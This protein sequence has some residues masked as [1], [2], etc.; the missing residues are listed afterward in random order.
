MIVVRKNPIVFYILPRP[1]PLF[2]ASHYAGLLSAETVG[3]K[4][5]RRVSINQA[6]EGV[7]R[8]RVI[9]YREGIAR[10]AVLTSM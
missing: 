10:S 6:M 2:D 5:C 4:D 7:H 3:G 9:A 1:R 8:L